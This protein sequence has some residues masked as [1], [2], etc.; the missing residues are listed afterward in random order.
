MTTLP[1]LSVRGVAHIEYVTTTFPFKTLTKVHSLPTYELLRDIKNELKANAASVQCDLGG[2]DY[3]HLGL[4]LTDD[5]YKNVTTS[6]Y[7][8]L[9]H[10]GDQTI[11]ATTI[12]TNSYKLMTI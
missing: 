3:G 8:R 10:I 7:I 5:E 12:L 11:T 2:S 4:V 1:Q 9:K 6:A